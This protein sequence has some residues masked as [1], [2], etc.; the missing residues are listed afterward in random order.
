M[1]NLFIILHYLE[2]RNFIPLIYNSYFLGLK[3]S[4]IDKYLFS[5]ENLIFYY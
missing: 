1:T 2:I 4:T 5:F 3:L